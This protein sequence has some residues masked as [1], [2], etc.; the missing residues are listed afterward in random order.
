MSD[1]KRE[2]CEDFTNVIAKT[3]LGI[4]KKTQGK[5][6]DVY[7]LEDSVVLVA[8]DRL[9]AF[10]RS[11]AIIPCKGRVLN[12]VSQFWFESTQDIIKN[13]MISVPH[14]NVLIAKKCTVFQIEFVVR[15][16]I[17]GSSNTSLWTHYSKGVRSY[18]GHQFPDG[19]IKH[20]KLD[21]NIVTPTT[22]STVHDELIDK[23]GIVEQ[24]LMTAEDFDFCEQKALEL[25][26]F[27][28]KTA[29]EHGLILVDTKYEFGK[30]NEGN[31]LLVDEI[32]T[33]DSSRYWLADSYDAKMEKK[34]DPESIDKDIV[35]RWIVKNCD[36]YKDETLPQA[37]SE[38]LS[39]LSSRYIDLFE[40]ITG[41]KFVSGEGKERSEQ[42]LVEKLVV[43]GVINK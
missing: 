4:G 14:P 36:P 25:F 13:H 21:K 5:V 12:S 35:R 9:S 6:R 27:G 15:G 32:H 34:E 42:G 37:P 22:K 23:K 10:D 19:L 18:C 2:E 40:M 28:Q 7:E 24:G 16:F 17:T 30:D 11:I 1:K 41:N 38:L 3:D 26:A 43:A 33:P 29:K 20:Q 39:T 8:T 31:I